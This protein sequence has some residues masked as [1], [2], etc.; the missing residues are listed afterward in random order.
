MA[1]IKVQKI[2]EEMEY[3]SDDSIYNIRSWGA[4]LSFRELISMY[5]EGTLLKP[6]L[7]RKYVW[8]KDIAS[9]FIDSILLGLPV[10]SIFLSKTREHRLIVDG[11]QRIMTVND[12][13]RGIF[14]G[15]EKVFK[16]SNS[17]K[18]N[19][20]WRGKAFQELTTEEQ[21]KIKNTT[22]HAIVFEQVEPNND[23][24]MYQVFE[25]I[26]TSGKILK[27]QE[28]RNCVYHGN[29]NSLIMELNKNADWRRLLRSPVEDSRML[30][31]EF[32][33]RFFAFHDLRNRNEKNLVSINLNKYLNLY[34]GENADMPMEL[35][36][37][38]TNI[39]VNTMST[40]LRQLQQN[41]FSNLFEISDE[42]VAK[43]HPTIFDSIAIAFSFAVENNVDIPQDIK[44][45]H[46]QLLRDEAFLSAISTRTTKLDAIKTRI[47][48]ACEYL[49]GIVYAW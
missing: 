22:I 24:A 28:I 41:A 33:L 26:N 23:T 11:Y 14:S 48:R 20:R 38:K 1:E 32:I 47:N 8:T 42:F 36:L 46:K 5:K 35:Q 49:F 31:M 34:M 6:E 13:V 9:R 10:P 37:E 4:D 12:Y 2:K 19:S 15:T 27:P 45:R 16:L 29:F 17:D 25:R 21:I 7:Q 39:F 40:I 44:L 18:I 30:D 3:Y 43:F